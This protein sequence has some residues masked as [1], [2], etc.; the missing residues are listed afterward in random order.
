MQDEVKTS[1][2]KVVG[3]RPDRPDGIDKVTGR[4]KFGADMYAPGMLHAAVVRSPHAHAKIVKIDTSKAEAMSDVKAV[5]TRADFVEGLTGEDWNILENVMAGEKALYDGHAVAAVAA[6]SALAARDAAKLVEV[7]YQ[8]LPHVTDVDKAMEEGAPV[9]REGATDGSVP[10]GMHPNVVRVHESGHGDVEKGFADADLVIEDTFQTE[11]THQGYIEPHACLAQLGS[12]GRGELWCCTQGHFNV[13]KICA[14]L[15]GSDASQIRVTASEIGGGFG[16]KTAVF[17][18]PVALMLSRKSNRPVKLVMSRAEVFRA[19]GPTSS[20][21]MDVKIGMTSDGKITAC[22]GIFRLQGGAFPGA[23]AEFTA[24]CAFAPYAVENVHQL[25][26][27]VMTNRPKQAAYRAPGSPMAAFAVES[28]VDELCNQLGLDPIETRLKNASKEG[29]KASFGPPFARIGLVET[30]EAAKSHDHYAAPLGEGEGRGISCGFWF[31]HGGETAVSLALS[32]D[33]TA[34]LSVGTPD[35]GG[36]R[37]SMCQM[38]AE[39]LGI[40][41]DKIRTTIADTATLGYNEVSHGSRVT[42]ASGLATIK[43]ARDAVDKLCHRAAAKWGIDRDAVYWE[44]GY[45]KPSGPN[46]GDFEPLS[47]EKLTA[48]MGAT[49]GPIVGHFEATPEGAGVSFATH[50]VDA[51]VDKETGQTSVVR[52]TVVQDAGKAIHPTYVEGQYQ[53]GAAQGIGWALNEEYIYG[54][55]GRLQ[56]S[57]FLDYRI[58]VASDLPMIDTVIVEVPNPGHPYGVRGVGETSICPPLAAIANAVSGAAGVRLRQLPMS[59]PRILEALDQQAN[60]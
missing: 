12:D 28:V 18:E 25:G 16:G 7:T 60:G 4:A 56:N 43:A 11:A 2:F 13:Q 50:I 38:A 46:A 40:S 15:V 3:T 39:E 14:K 36:S 57:N 58:P 17:I 48:R 9:I 27:D 20:T 8:M 19:T 54:D 59:P 24:M 55:D 51:K 22:Q 37:A 31:N 33:G 41:Y 44:D 32:E 23:P 53:G 45:A 5:V 35:I 6:T 21:S 49:G 52:Y 30:L 42:Y 1:D 29:T 10:E 34:A 26:Y 47:L